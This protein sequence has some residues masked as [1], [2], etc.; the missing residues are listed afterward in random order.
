MSLVSIENNSDVVRDT[1]SGAVLT[2][3]PTELNDYLTQKARKKKE[4]EQFLL[5]QERVHN[6]ECE[7][8]ILAASID[9]LHDIAQSC[10]SS[11]PLLDGAQNCPPSCPLLHK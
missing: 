1:K 7:V 10:S 11:C 2:T 6:L 9:H 3:N 4:Q 8:K 5:L